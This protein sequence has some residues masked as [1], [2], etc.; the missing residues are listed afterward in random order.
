MPSFREVKDEITRI[1]VEHNGIKATE[2]VVKI[3]A[4]ML[5]LDVTTAIAEMVRDNELVEV[6]FKVPA[7][8]YRAKSFLLP[9]NS[10]V[11]LR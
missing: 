11:S 4:S 8:P 2:L 10:E 5:I 1:V 7:M 9:K 3:P 6:E